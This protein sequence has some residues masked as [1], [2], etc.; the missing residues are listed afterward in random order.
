MADHKAEQIL[1]AFTTAVTGLATTGANVERD[2]VY[3]LDDA[4][5]AGLSVEMGSD[6]KR[7]DE[8]Q[9]WELVMYT[10]SVVINI[11]VKQSSSTPLSQ[12]LNQIRKEIVVALQ[13]APT[14]GL[15]FV[16]DTIEG[17]ALEPVNG[18]GEKPMS[19][20][21][22]EWAVVYQRSRTDPST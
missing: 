15:S 17:S 19:M 2:K 12:T 21:R 11:Y 10:L 3:N 8:T 1:D 5:T 16:Q 22:F 13:A 14:L 4:I 20:Q 9:G 7:D 6:I 18:P